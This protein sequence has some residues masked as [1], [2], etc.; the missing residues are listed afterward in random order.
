MRDRKQTAKAAR[1]PPQN[2]H[3]TAK[4]TATALTTATAQNQYLLPLIRPGRQTALRL[5]VHCS[6]FSF[7]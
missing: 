7:Q 1:H 6:M 2:K 4:A 3:A 5:T